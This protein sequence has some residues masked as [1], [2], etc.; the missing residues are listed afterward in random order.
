MNRRPNQSRS[1]FDAFSARDASFKAVS[2]DKHFFEPKVRVPL[3][4]RLRLV[5]ALLALLALAVN[6]LVNQFVFVRHVEVP[7]KGLSEAF[8]GFTILHISDLKGARFGGRQE[9]LS[10]ALGNEA[11]D[12]VILSGDMTSSR[13][14]AEPLYALLEILG[15]RGGSTPV[16]FIPGDSDPAPASMSYA[17]GGSPFAPWVLGAK[18]R[19]ATFLSSPAS[20]TRGEQTL[21]LT[22]NTHL[23]V[24]MDTLQRQYEQQYLAALDS[25][26]ENEIEL[27]TY[28]LQWLEN[29][30]SARKAI[31]EEDVLLTVSHAPL[32]PHEL[33]GSL[34]GRID[35]VLCGHY[36]GGL[37][38]FPGIGPLFVPSASL[39]RYGL[40]PGRDAYSGLTREGHTWIYTSPGL[41]ASD[42]LYPPFFF[43]LFNPPSVTLVSLTPSAM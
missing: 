34:T 4:K 27:A 24:D 8:D 23:S 16:Y 3:G 25:G 26:D 39:P 10:F 20:I 1:D 29:T 42:A 32:A 33:S 43:R 19:G 38:R 7:V 2:P 41:G 12:A 6:F 22:T 15:E 11:Y 31:K 35:L 17:A 13:G 36:L 5:L 18:Q 28:N 21:W 9:F 37:M 40:F 14:N 30:R